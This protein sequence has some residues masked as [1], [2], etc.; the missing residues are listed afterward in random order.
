MILFQKMNMNFRWYHSVFLFIG[1]LCFFLLSEYSFDITKSLFDPES[2]FKRIEKTLQKDLNDAE[3]YSQIILNKSKKNGIDEVFRNYSDSLGKV[4]SKKEISI[5][6]FRNDRLVFWSQSLDLTNVKETTSRYFI[7][8]I[9]NAWYVGQWNVSKSD[10]TFTL[11]LLKHNY[12]YQN[13]FLTNSYNHKLNE[14][15]G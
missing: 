3:S 4:L 1:A 5:F 10:K 13:K 8:T 12:P 14:L 9:Q 6:L 7:A 2:N 11:L 15:E